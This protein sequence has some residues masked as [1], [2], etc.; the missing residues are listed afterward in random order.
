MV[1]MLCV[2]VWQGEPGI[3]EKKLESKFNGQD[4]PQWDDWHLRKYLKNVRKLIWIYLI[5]EHAKH[6]EKV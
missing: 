6:Q 1:E 2:C 4:R 5:E 3:I